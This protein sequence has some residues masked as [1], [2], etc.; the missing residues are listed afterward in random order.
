MPRSNQKRKKRQWLSIPGLILKSV[1]KTMDF[2]QSPSSKM[3]VQMAIASAEKHGLHLSPGRSNPGLGNCAF[4][5]CIYNVND[6]VIFH[7][8]YTQSIDYYR[9]IW[10][11]DM[12]NRSYSDPLLNNGYSRDDW[13]NGWSR[14][15]E[16]GKYEVEHFGDL[17]I[18]AIGCGL[19]KIL[20]I[21]NTNHNIAHDPISVI[22]PTAYGIHPST[23]I[24]V[25]VAYNGVHYE[26]LHPISDAD[27]RRSMEIVKEYQNGS[28]HFTHN[29]LPDLIKLNEHIMPI[30]E[31][32]TITEHKVD[33]INIQVEEVIELKELKELEALDD[34]P[35]PFQKK[36]IQ[37]DE[38]GNEAVEVKEN[39]EVEES[40]GIIKGRHVPGAL[41]YSFGAKLTKNKFPKLEENLH[42]MEYFNGKCDTDNYKN[43]LDYLR[44][45]WAHHHH[46]HHLLHLHHHKKN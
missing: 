18:P 27:I 28:Y 13:H 44:K 31:A 39:E 40:Y 33:K 23:S 11:T 42:M 43:I 38:D 14:M 34:S 2:I 3:V 4:E 45:V 41:H 37:K 15:K 29:D 30:N 24:P 1:N 16:P 10:A 6:R 32:E 19:Q 7:Q 36:G 22:D 35:P 25:I 21:F 46:H 8:K 20:L 5:A 12:E 9:R 26:S 17:I